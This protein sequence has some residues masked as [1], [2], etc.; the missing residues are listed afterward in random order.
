MSVTVWTHPKA[1]LTAKDAETFN[2]QYPELAVRHTTAFHDRFLILDGAEG[3]LV[4][5]SLKDA[6][7]KSFAISRIEDASII[8]LILDK[9]SEKP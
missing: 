8:E 7:K 1:K 4:G 2:A 9:L 3:Y 6:G 5:A